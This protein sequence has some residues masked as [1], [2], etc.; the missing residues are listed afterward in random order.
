MIILTSSI[1]YQSKFR[2]RMIRFNNQS[3]VVQISNSRIRNAMSS[4]IKSSLTKTASRLNVVVNKSNRN[5]ITNSII[6]VSRL[7]TSLIN[8]SPR[9]IMI[10]NTNTNNKL[11][12]IINTSTN[13]NLIIITII[14]SSTNNSNSNSNSNSNK[15][16]MI[17]NSI[18]NINSNL[19]NSNSNLNNNNSN[20]NNSNSNLNSNN[21][22]LIMVMSL[23]NNNR[24][25]R[26]VICKGW[27][28]GLNKEMRIGSTILKAQMMKMY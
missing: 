28:T 23:N 26:N 16:I 3:R 20:L 18:S 12:L 6:L 5:M 4:W 15:V 2:T 7:I 8:N 19:N 22:K 13:N 9:L 27:M 10:T 1:V 24:L 25:V 21:N 14:N 11:I 17:I